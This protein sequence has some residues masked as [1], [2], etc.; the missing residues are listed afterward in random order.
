MFPKMI[1]IRNPIVIPRVN[2][3]RARTVTVFSPSLSNFTHTKHREEDD[4]NARHHIFGN[5]FG[6][7][8]AGN[9]SASSA[10]PSLWISRQVVSTEIYT[11]SVTLDSK[12]WKA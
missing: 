11:A 6:P 10:T 4:M 7:P 3:A 5:S 2:I 9:L 1:P 12:I 8:T